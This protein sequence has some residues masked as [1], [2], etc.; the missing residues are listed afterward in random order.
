MSAINNYYKDFECDERTNRLVERILKE[1][2][3]LLRWIKNRPCKYGDDFKNDIY[4]MTMYNLCVNT[5]NRAHNHNMTDEQIVG[6]GPSS[7]YKAWM[8]AY[9]NMPVNIRELRE[10]PYS[11]DEDSDDKDMPSGHILSPT[12]E[13]DELTRIGEPTI[14]DLVAS[15]PCDDLLKKA[16]LL[17]AQGYKQVEAAEMLGMRRNTL[18]MRMKALRESSKFKAWL[19][20]NGIDFKK[21]MQ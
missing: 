5:Y 17:I 1:Y 4:Q 6:Y 7:L 13:D 15:M 16:I 21:M 14:E 11:I 2:K 19:L 18:N 20:E 10:Y 3:P 8:D 9:K 12:D